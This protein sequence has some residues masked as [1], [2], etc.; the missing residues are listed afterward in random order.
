MLKRLGRLLKDP[1]RIL[2]WATDFRVFRLMPDERFLKLLFWL[3][4]KK[5]LNLTHPRTFNEKMQWLKVHWRKPQMTQLVDKVAVKEI[6]RQIAPEVRVIPTLGIWDS[7][8]EID[9]DALPEQFV[10]KP[11][12]T[13]GDVYIC[14]DRQ[15]LDPEKLRRVATRW[16]KREYYWGQREWPYKDVPP[17]LL[18][19]P[20]LDD[21]SGG[22]RDYKFFCFHGQPRF[23]YLSQGMEDHHTARMAFMDMEGRAL[24]FHRGDYLRFEETPEL[25]DGFERLRAL[26]TRIAEQVDVPF[27]RVDLYTFR[28]EVYFGEIT[29]F[30]CSGYMPFEPEEW[31]ERIGSYMTLPEND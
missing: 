7:F 8:D 30:P 16:L 28:D 13:S 2:L 27:V 5:R 11:S 14:R 29:F 22:L 24:P 26:S 20:Y 18:A 12:H 6:I 23:F 4:M 1:S 15:K 19:E 3:N 9:L 21:G 10:L 25:P 31:D 17:K